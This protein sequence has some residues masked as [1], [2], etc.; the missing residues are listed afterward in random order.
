[1]KPLR[2]TLHAQAALEERNIDRGEVEL[3]IAAP[4]QVVID[5]PRRTVLARRYV[6]RRLGRQMLLRIVVEETAE[7]RVVVTVYKTSRFGKYLKRTGP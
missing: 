3:T 7:E 5:P 4:E 6:V 2:W 1:M